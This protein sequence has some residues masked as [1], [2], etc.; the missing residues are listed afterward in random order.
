MTEDKPL[1]PEERLAFDLCFPALLVPPE[2]GRISD[3]HG[4]LLALGERTPP[5]AYGGHL[6]FQGR[7]CRKRRQKAP[8][9]EGAVMREA[10]D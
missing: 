4:D 1:S 10:H 9:A 5:P 2:S 3:R 8:S 7:H 6:P